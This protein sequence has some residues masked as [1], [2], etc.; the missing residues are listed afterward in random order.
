MSNTLEQVLV[1]EILTVACNEA[2]TGHSTPW[3]W[4]IQGLGMLRTY[5]GGKDVRLHV[6]DERYDVGASPMHTHPWDMT[7]KIIA[8]QLSQRRYLD[9]GAGHSME[10]ALP[11]KRQTI[12]CG[13]GG[14]L[15]GTPEDWLLCPCIEEVYSPGDVYSQWSSE[16]HTTQ[17]LRGTVTLVSRTFGGDVDR[18]YVYWPHDEE[19]VSAEPRDATPDEVYDILSHSL[20]RWFS[21]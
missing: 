21:A 15:E 10:G 19:W 18:A 12:F 16:I 9:L 7:S 14:G 6:W 1:K 11:Y 3:D 20:S 8:G 4:T 13:A 17:S 2:R 5:I